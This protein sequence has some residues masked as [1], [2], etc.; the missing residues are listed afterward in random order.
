[1]SDAAAPAVPKAHPAAIAPYHT[2]CA[3]RFVRAVQ[4]RTF[5]APVQ[6][7]Y[8]KQ[9]KMVAQC[10]LADEDMLLTYPD[11]SVASGSR[12]G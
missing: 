8:G 11:D 4:I 5:Q 1:M 10:I 9:R 7:P 12:H 2:T 6:K 3:H